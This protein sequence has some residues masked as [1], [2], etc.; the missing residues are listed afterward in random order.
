M[1]VIEWRDCTLHGVLRRAFLP[2]FVFWSSSSAE[3]CRVEDLRSFSRFLTSEA[4]LFVCERGVL[5]EY[6]FRW[7]CVCPRF[8]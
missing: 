1:A 5:S 8:L 6:M 3:L 2:P 4:A 7:L